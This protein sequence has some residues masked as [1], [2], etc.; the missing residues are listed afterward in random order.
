MV[1]ISVASGV[2]IT[3]KHHHGAPA[4]KSLR[5]VKMWILP[6]IFVWLKAARI[7]I[8]PR[9][10]QQKKI[11]NMG[12][13]HKVHAAAHFLGIWIAKSMGVQPGSDHHLPGLLRSWGESLD[14]NQI[15]PA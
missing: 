2:N 13:E 7:C 12:K 6:A 14:A 8:S 1:D 4:N 9:C 3:S 11:G 5:P 15:I 10:F